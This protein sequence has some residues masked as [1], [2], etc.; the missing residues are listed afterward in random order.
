M[1]LNRVPSYQYG[2]YQ[3]KFDTVFLFQPYDEMN[4]M[5]KKCRSMLTTA[6]EKARRQTVQVKD[7]LLLQS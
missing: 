5:H 1:D 7:D 3:L 4:N 2:S 6:V